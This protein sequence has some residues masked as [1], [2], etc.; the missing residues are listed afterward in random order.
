MTLTC[1]HHK[2]DGR[3]ER[4]VIIHSSIAHI[5][6]Q[7]LV[8]EDRDFSDDWVGT[9]GRYIT[10]FAYVELLVYELYDLLP[11][12]RVTKHGREHRDYRDR[13]R[14][15][16]ALMRSV[17]WSQGEV[18]DQLLEKTLEFSSLRNQIAHNPMFIEVWLDGSQDYVKVNPVITDARKGH[19]LEHITLRL[20]NTRLEELHTLSTKIAT[21]VSEV[22]GAI[23]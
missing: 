11:D 22:R 17:S 23:E 18:I 2:F 7:E 9:I 12:D 15:L 6:W 19:N 8:S 21:T 5:E 4:A 10:A 20:L 13:A 16:Q 14:L 3:S 1:C